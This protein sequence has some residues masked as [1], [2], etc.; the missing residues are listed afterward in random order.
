M[1]HWGENLRTFRTGLL[2]NQ[3]EMADY[4]EIDRAH[5]S[6]IETGN[7]K[8]TDKVATRF[9]LL[10]SIARNSLPTPSITKDQK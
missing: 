6:R 7:R 9:I 2:L 5:L 3:Q 8:M 1:A 10:R 4:L